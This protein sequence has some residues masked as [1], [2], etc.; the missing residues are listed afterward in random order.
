MMDAGWAIPFGE[1]MDDP[2][3][4]GGVG[5][6]SGCIQRKLGLLGLLMGCTLTRQLVQTAMGFSSLDDFIKHSDCGIYFQQ[7]LKIN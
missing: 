5:Q 3:P 2:L 1:H 6:M 4:K 7:A